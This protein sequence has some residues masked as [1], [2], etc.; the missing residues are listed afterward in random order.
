MQRFDQPWPRVAGP[1]DR[2]RRFVRWL[3]LTLIHQAIWPAIVLV[4]GSVMQRPGSSP[5]SEVIGMMSGPVVA[6]LVALAFIRTNIADFPAPPVK[7]VVAEQA[8]LVLIGLPIM[9]LIGRLVAGDADVTAKITAV[10]LVNVA[11]YHLIHFG[12]VRA[13][14]PSP[15]TITT[16]FGISWA[17]HQIADALARDTGGS[18][19]YHA[20]AGFS[21]GVVVA[22][23]SQALH[24]WPGGRLTAPAAHLLLIYLIFGFS[25]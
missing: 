6:S 18:F 3:N 9:V 20:F 25:A 7:S 10:G 5:V 12:V 8:Q 2:L 4:T 22:V 24:R 14:F 19:I 17:I 15:Y 21:V 11:A 1:R 13:L 16:L 23:V